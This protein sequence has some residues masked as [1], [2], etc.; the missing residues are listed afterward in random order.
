MASLALPD[1]EVGRQGLREP[2]A[3]PEPTASPGLLAPRESREREQLGP[4]DLLGPM[5]LQALP[6]LPGPMALQGQPDPPGPMVLLGPLVL[7]EPE[8]R[9]R[10]VLPERMALRELPDP[11]EF[12]EQVKLGL[13]VH[14]ERLVLEAERLARLE[15]PAPPGQPDL[16]ER[17]Q[18][19]LPVLPA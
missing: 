10:R 16:R 2:P 4:Q 15:R 19:E 1:P 13:P 5:A 14:L 7:P 18:L 9:A 6:V 17:E 3:L 11:P 12:Q 8:R